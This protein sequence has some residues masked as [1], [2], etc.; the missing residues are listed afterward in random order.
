M[1]VVKME[2]RYSGR[3]ELVFEDDEAVLYR[4]LKAHAVVHRCTQGRCDA[5][6]VYEEA[7]TKMQNLRS[8]A[9]GA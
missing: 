2:Y 8:R 7:L 3:P 4:A 1:E 5:R 6:Q 9:S